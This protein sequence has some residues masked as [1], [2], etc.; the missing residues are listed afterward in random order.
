MDIHAKYTSLTPTI[1]Q[2]MEHL[3]W[4]THS[5]LPDFQFLACPDKTTEG[6]DWLKKTLID[7]KHSWQWPYLWTSGVTLARWILDNPAV[8]MNKIVYDLGTGQGAVAI[9]AKRAGAKLVVGI[10]CCAYSEY[11]LE[12]NSERNKVTTYFLNR[13]IIINLKIPDNCVV[14]ASDVI[15]GQPTSKYLL[16][17]FLHLSKTS[18]M[19]V[20]QTMRTNPSY[21]YPTDKVH[22]LQ[23][24]RV[25]VEFNIEQTKDIPVKIMA[26]GKPLN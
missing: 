15:Y 25:P 17:K 2:V 14:F 3:Q 21:E 1:D 10:D 22:Q 13:D 19:I 12:C 18:T 9:A 7:N 11:V 23:S 26:I 20:S 4:C 6:S 5:Y 16:N 8:V 24:K